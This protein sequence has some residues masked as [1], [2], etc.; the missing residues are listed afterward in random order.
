RILRNALGIAED[1]GALGGGKELRERVLEVAPE[2]EAWLPL[3]A[4]PVE[5]D[6]PSTP[7]VD[8]LQD[9]FRKPK[10]EQVVGELLPKVLEG[11]TFFAFEDVHWMDEASSD[12]LQHLA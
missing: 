7:E 12:L 3:I 2:L 9:E 6:V 5:V 11:P 1:A 8:V 4:L 10:L